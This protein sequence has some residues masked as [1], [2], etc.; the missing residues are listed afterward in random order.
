MRCHSKNG[1][2]EGLRV[3]EPLLSPTVFVSRSVHNR[4]LKQNLSMEK[5]E[6]KLKNVE[7]WI[8]FE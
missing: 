2:V 3:K 8:R 6:T 5:Q 7:Y 4:P 1:D